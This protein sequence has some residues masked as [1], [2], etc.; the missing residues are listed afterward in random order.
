MTAVAG[1]RPKPPPPQS[2][3][4]VRLPFTETIRRWIGFVGFGLLVYVPI[5]LTDPGKV[6]AD[7]KTYLY[8]D[9]G[10]LLSEAMRMWDP[11]IGM[12]TVSH[13]TI[14]YLFPMGPFYWVLEQAAGLP[15]WV[16]QRLWMGTILFA[17][18]LGVWFLL[19]TLGMRG[20]GVVVGVLAYTFTPYVLQYS[21]RFSV[22]LGPWAALGWMIA[23]VV[24]A[25]RRGGWKYPALFAI[26]V[27]LVGSVNATALLFAGLGPLLFIPYSVWVLHDSTLR[28]A[29]Q[30]VWRTG[31]LTLVT[32]L[33][34]MS[35]LWAQGSYGLD[36]LKYTETVETVS[37]TSYANEIIRGLGYWFF[38]FKDLIGPWND[39][40]LNMTQWRWLIFVSY[41]VPALA[42]LSG[43]I[44]RWRDR[45]FF[46]LLVLVGMI[47]AVGASP[48]D[49]PSILGSL[50]KDFA[51]SSSAG[52]ALRS[53]SRAV[54][55]VALGMAGL[56]AAG[57]TAVA[58][59]LSRHRHGWL[60][61][62]VATFIGALVLLNAPG[63]WNGGL[64][65][66]Y[67]ERD[68]AIPQYW[69]KAL[70]YLDSKPHDTRVLGLPGSDF[71]A[72]RWGVTID[73]IE[74]GLM[75]RP[76]VARELVPWGSPA[77]AGF[78]EALDR[79]IQAGQ[80]EPDAIA[81]VARMMGVGDILLR[82]DLQTERYNLI[83][84]SQLWKLFSP[85]P[86]NGLE[87]AR[88]FGTKIAGKPALPRIDEET[89]A[90]GASGKEPPPV[91]VLGVKQPLAI[92]RTTSADK[93]LVLAGDA[94]GVMDAS[95][96]GLLD[97][98]RIL[99]FSGSYAKDPSALRKQVGRDATLVVTDSNRKRS[100]RWTGARDNS[101]ATEQVDE[102]PLKV[103]QRDAR[104]E[105]FPGSGTA[106][107]TVAE[108]RG[109]KVVEASDYGLA[110]LAPQPGFRAVRAV[111]GDPQTAWEVGGNLNDVEGQ[112][113]R[114][115]ADHPITTDHVNLLQPIRGP[116]G[117]WVDT[118]TLTFDGKDPVRVQL[119]PQSRN[120]S[121][122][123]QTITFPEH[124]FTTFQ[125]RIDD[126]HEKPRSQWRISA[127]PGDS[128]RWNASYVGLAEIRLRDD[129]PGSKDLQVDEYIR[130]PTDLLHAVGTASLEHPLVLTMTRDGRA[131]DPVTDSEFAL[132]RIFSIPTARDFA[133][134][135]TAR[136]NAGAPDDVIDSVLGFPGADQGGYTV[137]TSERLFG[138]VASR[139]SSAIDDDPTTAWTTP[140]GDILGQSVR[141][142]T[143]GRITFD[144]LDLQVADDRFHSVPT[145]LV[146]TSDDGTSRR[147][148]VPDVASEKK[149]GSTAR[150]PVT[151][152]PVSGTAFT[153]TIAA[154]REAIEL[155]Y[156]TQQPNVM[157][158]GISEL[159]IPGV[160][161]R[162]AAVNVP[163]AC[164]SDL[165]TID[166]AAVP[167]RVTGT[168][169]NAVTKGPLTVERCDPDGG[170]VSL[171]AGTHELR[172]VPGL[173]SGIDVDRLTLSSAAG[174]AAAPIS[175]IAAT[176]AGGAAAA[177]RVKVVEQHPTS[178]T[179]KLPASDTPYWLVLGQSNNAGWT[180]KANGTDLGPSKLVDG[181]ANGWL[182]QPSSKPVTV[183]LDWTP[184]RI[185]NFAMIASVF[186]VLLCLGILIVAAVRRQRRPDAADAGTA[187]PRQAVGVTPLLQSPFTARG[188]RPGPV[189]VVV[190]GVLSGVAAAVLIRPWCGLFVGGLVVLVLVV[191]RLRWVL[192]LF[193]VAA[194]LVIGVAV[195]AGQTKNNWATDINWPTH[196]WQLRTLGWLAVVTLAADVVVGL[197][198]RAEPTEHER[199]PGDPV[200][201]EVP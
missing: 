14:G 127:K 200:P 88:T 96:V 150:V 35:G 129:A 39:A 111:D 32:S 52:L 18:G 31:L 12:G 68:E 113:I 41:S 72:Y 120:P 90:I 53:T 91:A 70:R 95:A 132:Q 185:V 196:F 121:A 144:H 122:V 183:A 98:K 173:R 184:Q 100:H 97:P 163:G 131:V 59:A 106:Q 169:E 3:R 62:G 165:L 108:Q 174:G 11:E 48:F 83:R 146:I 164:R 119:G 20:P 190:T 143:P 162:P 19:K 67:L 194:V 147:V 191:P 61:L 134:G 27:Q 77:S 199:D 161:R 64:Y 158:V 170:A 179:V 197:V 135:G 36:I 87:P 9:P 140:I 117:R 4:E 93:P 2:A 124:T 145:E 86:P 51:A 156:A 178:A 89:I 78:L 85:T 34:W 154:V 42:L 10:R 116:R 138:D 155:D 128:V 126:V 125:L 84:S 103:D 153:V 130:M 81:P 66:R 16:A 192:S 104:L 44:V 65:S 45:A 148:K 80:L 26:T 141:V 171:P 101:G 181:Y 55:L 21:S 186:G 75:D 195:V 182:I 142:E 56:L 15:S 149:R 8:L 92:T 79:R 23:F 69:S 102:K 180:A 74:P 110:G 105:L 112:S 160:V 13:Q 6:E 38:Y 167:I 137:T 54:P 71:A 1:T 115:V 151:F 25:L 176:D 172:V 123:G 177:P 201:S 37:L 168:T 82:M 40:V 189:A 107:Q 159:G 46:V 17:A 109:V 188:S 30:V 187:D 33:W 136:I 133:V 198:R 7:T 76:Y 63:I 5:L 49:N 114:I 73:P 24:L 28:R 118:A 47:V 152:A 166:G 139:G 22:L 43:V 29:W 60:G 175:T 157:P 57:V 50:F 99:L 94:D 193:P 58:D